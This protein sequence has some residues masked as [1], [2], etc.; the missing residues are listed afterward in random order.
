MFAT[1]TLNVGKRTVMKAGCIVPLVFFFRNKSYDYPASKIYPLLLP[2]GSDG[3][4]VRVR[5]DS[6]ELAHAQFARRD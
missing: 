4:A 6:L 2:E 5:Q 3:R 1:D